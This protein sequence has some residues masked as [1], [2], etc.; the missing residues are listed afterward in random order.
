VLA[1]IKPYAR[2]VWRVGQGFSD[3][4]VTF[5][6]A[7]LCYFV[8]FSI[9]PLMLVLVAIAG[10]F[11]SADEAMRQATR[12]V[13]E[14]FPHQQ[15][16]L[17]D[18][19]RQVM[20][21]RGQASL[22]GFGALLWT[23]KNVFLSLS[24]AMNEIWHVPGRNWL[25]ENLLATIVAISFGLLI[26]LTSMGLAIA[27]ALASYRIPYIGWSPTMIPGFVPFLVSV[28]PFVSAVLILTALYKLLPHRYLR[29]RD[30]APGAIVA[31]TAWEVLRRLFGWYLEHVA[32]YEM[33]Y[34]SLGG[35]VGFLFWIYV[36]AMIFLLGV[37]VAKAQTNPP[38]Q[39]LPF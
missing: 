10:H 14:L 18:L 20:T 6:A 39:P 37:E 8:F 17:I 3:D 2:F 36:S 1:P 5:L 13:A 27:S 12:V 35:I 31:A 23:G 9:F 34:G 4:Q 19:L 7:S 25:I 33:V 11:L 30:V 24:Y 15:G 38:E 21:F 28:G 26:V 29:W 16:F 22:L 32:R